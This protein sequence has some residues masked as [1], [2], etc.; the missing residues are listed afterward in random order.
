[1]NQTLFYPKYSKMTHSDVEWQK[2]LD[3]RPVTR[4]FHPDKGYKYD[5]E[6]PYEQ[7]Y[8]YLADRLGHPEILGTPAERLMR[9]EGEIYHPNF[10]DQPFVKIPKPSPHPSLN[11]EEGAVLYENTKLLEWAKFWNYSIIFGYVWAAIF[12][13]YQLL[14]KTHMPLEYAYDNLF[15]QYYQRSM[16]FW[17]NNALHVPIVSGTVLYA[18]YITM[19]YINN[20]WKDYVV[21]AQF[22]KDREL[23]FVT[24]VSPYGSTDEEV[25]EMAH[26]E[27]L[28]PSVKSAIGLLSSQDNDGLYD[29]SCL[30]TQRSLLFY[31]DQKYWNPSERKN[32]F[33]RTMNLFTADYVAQ[34]RYSDAETF[35]GVFA[36]TN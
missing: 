3:A 4:N 20:V 6:V 14:F 26:I 32:F 2:E 8:E 29:A 13:P 28:P 30:N 34:P 10:L 19:S 15:Y 16:F 27:I 24:R 25:Y 1:M 5:V 12:V 17:D 21:R 7:R 33:D 35:S 18:T 9:L 31:G 36:D 11:F 23:L 22:S